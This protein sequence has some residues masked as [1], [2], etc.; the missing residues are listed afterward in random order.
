MDIALITLD[1][2][3]TG[4]RVGCFGMWTGGPDDVGRWRQLLGLPRRQALRHAVVGG[5]PC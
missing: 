2:A 5:G 1:R 3:A 4:E